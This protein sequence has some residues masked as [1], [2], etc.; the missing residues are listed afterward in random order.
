VEALGSHNLLTARLAGQ[1]GM[2]RAWL[3]AG[4]RF[5]EGSTV[6][7]TFLPSGCRW[8]DAQTGD[9]LPWKTLEVA[10]PPTA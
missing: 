3:P 6:G 4:V 1:A 7:L 2:V 9:A 8:F 5:P 10:C